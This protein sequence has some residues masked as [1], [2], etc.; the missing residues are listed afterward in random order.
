MKNTDL[1][2]WIS[3][4]QSIK[5]TMTPWNFYLNIRYLKVFVHITPRNE[6]SKNRFKKRFIFISIQRENIKTEISKCQI[7]T[8]SFFKAQKLGYYF[9][10]SNSLIIALHK[11]FS[12]N[13]KAYKDQINLYLKDRPSESRGDYNYDVILSFKIKSRRK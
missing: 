3:L 13:L 10:F 7:M 11:K 4:I 9:N 8:S 6:K 2:H 1:I 12:W 5:V